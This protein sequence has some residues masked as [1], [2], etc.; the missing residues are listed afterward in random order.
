MPRTTNRWSDSPSSGWQW[1]MGSQSVRGWG[2]GGR[3][4]GG[5]GGWAGGAARARPS[6]RGQGN[7]R[8]SAGGRGNRGRA[9][10]RRADPARPARRPPTLPPVPSPGWSSAACPPPTSAY[11]APHPA[12]ASLV[13]DHLAACLAAGLAATGARAEAAAGQASFSLGPLPPTAAADQLWVAR[14]LLHRVAGDRGLTVE[15]DAL[16]PSI[17]LDA[18]WDGNAVSIKLSTRA[19]RD[20]ACG[21][22]ALRDHVAALA[23]GDAACVESYGPRAAARLA[24]GRPRVPGP[25]FSAGVDDATASVRL[26]AAV[27]LH[28]RGHYEDQRPAGGCDP[29]AAVA[30]LLTVALRLPPVPSLDAPPPPAR[31]P[32]ASR[33]TR[34]PRRRRS[35]RTRARAGR[36]A[37]RPTR[38][39]GCRRG[40]GRR[41]GRRPARRPRAR[42]RGASDRRE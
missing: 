18:P 10:A 21:A 31:K 20:E 22:T 4:G 35:A 32:A 38:R 24:R 27:A 1:R 5:G 40:G 33:A 23:A 13:D 36:P 14:W 42:G 16:P 29:Y 3:G 9:R 11:G 37:S 7:D 28:G 17:P 25:A 2:G 12:L 6:R 39:W 19:T 8:A 30:A 41:R 34:S 26:P 15:L